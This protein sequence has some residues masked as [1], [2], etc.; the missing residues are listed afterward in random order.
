MIGCSIWSLIVSFE[1]PLPVPFSG[2]FF[3]GKSKILAW[4]GTKPQP[5]DG[6]SM[7]GTCWTLQSTAEF[8]QAH[9]VPQEA[10]PPAKANEVTKL[11]LAE[12]L[13]VIGEESHPKVLFSK[14]QLWGAG[15]PLNT[16]GV[17]CLV[18]ES[19]QV[20]VCG[21]WCTEPSI[22]GAALSGAALAAELHACFRGEKVNAGMRT[23]WT[24]FVT[25]IG[26]VNLGGTDKRPSP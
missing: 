20:G 13:N 24:P 15:G 3:S 22:Q 4:A 1:A 12:L 7:S 11:M 18:E 14:L 2:L 5:H 25:A 17:E 23:K 10:V 8:G 26:A 21:D 6:A 19:A 9:K 16:A